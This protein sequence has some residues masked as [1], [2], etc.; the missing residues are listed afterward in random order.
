[1]PDIQANLDS[2]SKGIRVDG[3]GVLIPWL[4]SESQLF[5]L[6]PSSTFAISEGGC[7]PML[8]FKFLG[9][10][11]LWGF[12]FVSHPLKLLSEL[13]FR[14]E[15]LHSPKRSYLRSAARLHKALGPPNYVES[16]ELG[17][18]AW[19]F[20]GIVIDNSL[21]SGRGPSHGKAEHVLSVRVI[22]TAHRQMLDSGS[23]TRATS[24]RSIR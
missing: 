23:V 10:S 22:P 19:R 14:N 12:N 13:Q 9:F 2:L 11:A 20:G 1:M 6:F 17:Q 5:E 7:W 4:T 24:L 15:R 3:Y 21:R 8:R 18:H 16:V